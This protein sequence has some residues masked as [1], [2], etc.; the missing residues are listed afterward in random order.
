MRA[1]ARARSRTSDLRWPAHLGLSALILA[2]ADRVALN[3]QLVFLLG[4]VGFMGALVFIPVD[5][6]FGII[7]LVRNLSDRVTISAGGS[8]N[9]GALIGALAIT[10]GGLRVVGR[11]QPKGLGFAL[12]LMLLLSAWTVVG[13]VNFGFDGTITREFLR[14]TSII[15]LGLVA[16]VSVRRFTELERFAGLV[17]LVT[18]V[19]AVVG[20]IQWARSH[21]L[22]ERLAGTFAHSNSAAAAIGVALGLSLWKL[23]ELRTRKY[24]WAATIL[25]VALLGTRSLGGLAEMMVMMLVYSILARKGGNR[26]PMIA[27]I[28]AIVLIAIFSLSPIGQSRVDE[29][30]TTQSF[31]AAAAG[32]QTNSLDWR[33]GNW[34]K[35]LHVW[36]SHPFFGF[37][38]GATT[39]LVQPDH[40][41]PHSDV[42]RLLVETGV[43]GF[44]IFAS[45][46]VM[47]L[48]A[49][50][51]KAREPGEV[52]RFAGVLFAIVLG[53]NTHALVN[54]ITLETSTTYML[55][56]LVGG[57][58][59]LSGD[60]QPAREDGSKGESVP[61]P[62]R[63]EA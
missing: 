3:P 35:L 37:G 31:S 1:I 48:V 24:A 12:T 43:F 11:R 52:G 55:A 63:A 26:R 9:I 38:A 19:P 18:M 40:N 49:L 45:L 34:A 16:S 5:L 36:K 8:A 6:F 46:Y 39:S 25:A 14:V 58:W 32:D 44:A 30:K 13:Y 33:F 22:S 50:Y 27:S 59:G 60:A 41:I 15:T 21:S 51:R 28:V 57:L 61:L 23:L 7:L 4:G 42:L 20:L 47:F 56:V 54:N 10:A 2:I 62:V 17:V 29:V 53:L